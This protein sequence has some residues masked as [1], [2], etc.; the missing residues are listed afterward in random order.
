MQKILNGLK[1]IDRLALTVLKVFT[2]VLFILLSLLVSA[3][4]FVRFVPVVSLHWFD[5]ILELLYAYLIFYGAAALWITREHFSVGDWISGRILRGARTKRLYRAVLEVLV[6]IFAVVFFYYSL[7]LTLLARDVTNVFAIPK[8]IL[9]SCLPCSGA[10]M[11]IYSIRNVAVEM[12]PLMKRK[13]KAGTP[14]P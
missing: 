4:V 11:I 10:I 3:N 6:L 9:Y 7:Q 1:T 8:R 5:E 14:P 13:T 2:I 12:I